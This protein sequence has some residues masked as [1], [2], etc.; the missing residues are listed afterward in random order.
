MELPI[1]LYRNFNVLSRKDAKNAKFANLSFLYSLRPL[2][3]TFLINLLCYVLVS[4]FQ[5]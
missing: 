5:N 4:E 3:E 2:R 1:F